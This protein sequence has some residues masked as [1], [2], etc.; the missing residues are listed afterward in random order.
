MVEVARRAEQL[1]DQ[2][3]GRAVR[4]ARGRELARRSALLVAV[5]AG[6]AESLVPEEAALDPVELE[7][8]RPAARLGIL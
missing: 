3:L 2:A 5:Q 6:L 7:A 4:L 1:L 8:A